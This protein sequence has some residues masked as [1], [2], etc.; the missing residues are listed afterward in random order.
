MS[1]LWASVRRIN[2][3]TFKDLQVY[4]STGVNTRQSKCS[5]QCLKRWA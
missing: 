3:E 1:K 2:K 4:L 5:K